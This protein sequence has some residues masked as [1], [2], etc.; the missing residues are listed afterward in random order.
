M[1]PRGGDGGE[2]E[3]GRER[4]V[5]ECRE[6]VGK[7][8]ARGSRAGT[9]FWIVESVMAPKILSHTPSWMRST[10]WRLRCDSHSSTALRTAV[11]AAEP[12][13]TIPDWSAK[14]R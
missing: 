11:S 6:P 7:E 8:E 13:L 9:H 4:R 2:V 3:E 10:F 12:F 1:K 14:S 5:S